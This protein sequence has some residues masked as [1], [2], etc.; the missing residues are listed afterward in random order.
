VNAGSTIP[1][2]L[3]PEAPLHARAVRIVVR[4]V[5]GL[6]IHDADSAAPAM[7]FHFFLSL[8]PILVL[9][10]FV[11]GQVVRQRGVDAFL[12][13]F[14]EAAPDEAEQ[15]V[16]HELERLAGASATPIA[17]LSIVG[18]LWLAA[19]GAHGLMDAF[20][21]AAGARRRSWWKKRV[22]AM[23][24]VTFAMVALAGLGWGMIRIDAVMHR[25]RVAAQAPASSASPSIP[26]PTIPGTKVHP[27]RAKRRIVPPLLRDASERAAA[28]G[29]ISL[30]GVAGLAAFFRFAVVHPPGVKRRAW[31]GAFVAFA[32]WLVV[33][34]GFSEYVSSL[35]SYALFYGSV[36]A[37]AVLLVWFYLTSWSLLI[38]AEVNAQLEGLRD[39]PPPR[40]KAPPRSKILR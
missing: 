16:R 2:L 17:P 24:W 28:L 8:I 30:L 4:I 36:A 26:T 27:A 11:L 19:T 13:P 34:W 40:P 29:A 14:L 18:F 21:R 5:Q 1:P 12:G 7:A 35:A 6:R 15:I 10:G 22:I 31:P 38:G 32:S 37:V 33:S 3:G 23:A 20:E 9:A 25:D 39:L